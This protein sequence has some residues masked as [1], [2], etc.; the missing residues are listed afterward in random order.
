MANPPS[1][2]FPSFVRPRFAASR[3]HRFFRTTAR[4]PRVLRAIAS[5]RFVR[6]RFPTSQGKPCVLRHCREDFLRTRFFREFPFPL[7]KP[8]FPPRSSHG[9]VRPSLLRTEARFR[10]LLK[11][12]RD[13]AKFIREFQS[14]RIAVLS[15]VPKSL[16]DARRCPPFFRII[17]V[18]PHETLFR[19][20][21][22]NPLPRNLKTPC[23]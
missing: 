11:A 4:I 21:R 15:A 17:S 13:N 9:V 6:S 7:R 23:G 12:C 8:R 16:S 14:G 2:R 18:R 19:C 10:L 20:L 22:R 5:S 1:F 3:H